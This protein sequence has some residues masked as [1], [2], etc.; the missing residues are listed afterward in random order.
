LQGFGNE[1]TWPLFLVS[2]NVEELPHG[3][4]QAALL[5]TLM[6]SLRNK[7]N[8]KM[9]DQEAGT[10]VLRFDSASLRI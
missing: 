4:I 5:K 9:V 6:Y 1:V 10:A 7:G 2:E 8:T 3:T